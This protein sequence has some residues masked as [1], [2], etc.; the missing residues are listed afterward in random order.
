M[1]KVRGCFAFDN[2][3]KKTRLLHGFNLA[4][5]GVMLCTTLL[6]GAKPIQNPSPTDSSTVKRTE[7]LSYEGQTI[8]SVELAGRPDVNVEEFTR[9]LPLHAGDAFSAAKIDQSIL[10]LE[11]TGQFQNIQ[12]DLRPE[13]EG[14]RA[15][16]IL[17]PAV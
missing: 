9:S 5:L 2:S 15:I 17:Q 7:L 13:L 8:S 14:V 11:R 12:V 3:A 4:L 6:A 1:H 10:A 16:F